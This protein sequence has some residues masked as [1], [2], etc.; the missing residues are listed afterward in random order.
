MCF[1]ARFVLRR[2]SKLVQKW[3]NVQSRAEVSS[4]VDDSITYHEPP[5]KSEGDK[6]V[7]RALS[8]STGLRA[9]LISDN[10]IEE[11]NS[12]KKDSIQHQAFPSSTK[13]S[14]SS[15]EH[16]HG[17]L[18]ACAVVVTVGSFSEPRQYQGLAHFLEHMVFM[19]SAKFPVENTFDAYVTKNGGY[20]NAYTECEE[21]TFFFEVEEAHLDKSLEIFI[22]LIKAPLLH[23]DSMAR[24]LSAIESEFEQTYLRDDIRRDQILASFAGDGYPHETF[25][26]GNL[27][28]LRQEFVEKTLHEALH[29]FWRKYYVSSRIIVCLQSKLSLNSLEEILLRHCLNIPNNDEINLSKNILNYDESFRDEFYREVFLVQ[30]VEDVC[31]L[32]LT[33]VLP[34]MK[35]QYRTK[36]DGFISHLIG[37]EGKGSLCAY[38]RR[39]LWCM[40]VTAGIG[41]SSFESN[42]IYSLFNICIYLTD[43][44]FE[45]IDDVMCATFAWMKLL[46]ES[47]DLKSSYKELQQITANNFRFQVELP[48]IDNV[49]NIAEN[50]RYFPYKDVLTG[51]HLYFEYDEAA[52]QLIKQH[53][54]AFKFNIMISSHIPYKDFKYDKEE[55]W[56]GTK[57]TTIPMPSKWFALW[58]EPGIIKDLIIPQPNPFITTDFTLHWQQ[59]GRPPIPRRP[60]LLLRNDLC[61]MWFRQDDTFQLPDGYIK[62]YFITPL[63][64]Q[65]A[66]NY[67]LGV[68]FTYLVEFSIIEQLYPAL[69]AGLT[70]SLY[71]GNKGLILNANGYN[72]KLP[73]IVEIIMNVLGS[74]ELDPA[75]LISFKELKKRQLFNAL[76]SGTALNLDLRLSILEKQHFSLVQK[77]DAIDDITLDDIELFKNSFYKQM[78][79]QALFQGN[80]ADEERHRIMHNVIDSFNSQKIDASTSLDKRVLQLPLGSYFLRAKVLN[81]NDSNT[82]ITNYYQIGPSSLR[83]ECLMDL[84]E[85]IVE[86]P[87]FNQLRTVEQLG[88]SLGLYQRVGYGVIAYVMTINTQETKHKSEIVESRIEA[89]RASIPE[90]ISQLSDEEFYELRETLIST[91]K[92]SDVNLDDEASRNWDE[93]VTMEY[94]FNHVEMQIQTLR[95]L[96]KQHVVNFLKEYEKTNFRKLS[97][98]VVGKSKEPLRLPTQSSS[99]ALRHGDLSGLLNEVQRNVSDDQLF[100][101][102]GNK[103]KI[104]LIGR[105]DDPTNIMNISSFKSKLPFYPWKP[106]MKSE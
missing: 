100:E 88:Y 13:R 15:L 58:H 78:Y 60:K 102:M 41:G 57:F 18:A 90:I 92:L 67:M 11:T 97:V 94:F 75:Q 50:I 1:N 52:L 61:E 62:I 4:F 10:S 48:F 69:L 33:W 24:E 12:Y 29:D 99:E 106:K 17:K 14:D 64:Q 6:K 101:K 53:L 22:N 77:Y 38:L 93:I 105:H 70:Y 71:M 89:F 5:D 95:G 81:D 47:S 37:Y 45:H 83:T 32:E 104:D 72:Q 31:K 51:S 91:K 20:C 35:F 16:F 46:N 23:P 34:P 28:S 26:W 74:L 84:V 43:D 76:I 54:S 59:A 19:G 3:L 73:L 79:I 42:S 68:L 27:Q 49:Q 103:I 39:R 56:F 86:E 30:P 96:T 21:T 87:Y 8:L 2:M 98:Q 55:R 63:I 7:Y 36:P 25:M 40:S 9:M 85:F 65:S 80:F 82:I 66:K 44:G